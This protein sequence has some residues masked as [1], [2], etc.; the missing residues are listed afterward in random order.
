M[1][2][3]VRISSDTGVMPTHFI[4][5]RLD[6]YA[7]R[8]RVIQPRPRR[9]ETAVCW[10]ELRKVAAGYCTACGKRKTSSRKEC[11]C[12]IVAD[13]TTTRIMCGQQKPLLGAIIVF[14]FRFIKFEITDA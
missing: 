8:T 5:R 4:K 10:P 7:I 14:D 3:F 9:I 13:D 1:K 6:F 2:I 11:I 12:T